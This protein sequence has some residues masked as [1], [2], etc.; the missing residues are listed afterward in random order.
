MIVNR[1]YIINN[2]INQLNN[3]KN[4]Y[5]FSKKSKKN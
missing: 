2:T 5:M 4:V 1:Q 3:E